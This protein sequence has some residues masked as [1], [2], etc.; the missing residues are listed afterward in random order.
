MTGAEKVN[1]EYREGKISPWEHYVRVKKDAVKSAE[2]GTD[3]GSS[4][5]SSRNGKSSSVLVRLRHRKTPI[6]A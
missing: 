5:G 1:K 6:L 2:Q 4:E 3:N